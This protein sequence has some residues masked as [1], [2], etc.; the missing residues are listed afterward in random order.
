MPHDYVIIGAGSAGCTLAHRLTEDPG[1]RVLLLEAGGWDRDPWIHI[2]LAWARM[3]QERAH[4]WGYDCEPEENVANRPV[5]CA[6]GRVVGGGQIQLASPLLVWEAGSQLRADGAA[7][8]LDAGL[9]GAAY[10]GGAQRVT[11][12][13]GSLAI[14]L[15]SEVPA[16]ATAALAGGAVLAGRFTAVAPDA[17]AA[18]GSL[19]L[20]L[21]VSDGSAI[22]SPVRQVTLSDASVPAAPGFGDNAALQSLRGAAALDVRSLAGSGVEQL[23]VRSSGGLTLAGSWALSLG[24][25][26]LLDAPLFTAAA[27][28]DVRLAAPSLQL[29]SSFLG[30]AQQAAP[31]PLAGSG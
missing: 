19:S 4:D 24:G 25:R 9:S 18:G 12:A 22:G 8:V 1:V 23:S 30:P 16:G 3:L 15:R 5:E 11:T 17:T 26:L 7:A 13:A 6:R 21:G 20:G 27:G 31:A 10:A 28:A 2:P 29:G 14:D